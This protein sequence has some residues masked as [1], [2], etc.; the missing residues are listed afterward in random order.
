M[1]QASVSPAPTAVS[2]L[3]QASFQLLKSSSSGDLEDPNYV[4]TFGG[5]ASSETPDEEG[6]VILRK[7]LNVKYISRRGY[8]NWDH[9]RQ[10][11]DQLGFITTAKV[12]SAGDVPRY[13]DLLGTPLSKTSSLYVEGSLYKHVP[14]AIRVIEMLKSIPRGSQ[15]GLGLSVDGSQLRSPSGIV[16]AIVQ[17]VAITPAPAHTET[18]CRLLKSLGSLGLGLSSS[19]DGTS[20][21]IIPDGL[22]EA[23]AVIRVMELRPTF[24]LELAKRLVRFFLQSK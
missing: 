8:V 16:Q 4:P 20:A 3:F 18:L 5:I 9:S 22:T 11:D 12:V 10:P 1:D 6:D 2:P 19:V 13:E 14:K 21:N 15:G 7:M 24:T 23:Q 17:G